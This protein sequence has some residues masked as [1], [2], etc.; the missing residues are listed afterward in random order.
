MLA[1]GRTCREHVSFGA[2]GCKGLVRLASV[3]TLG[4]IGP[5]SPIFDVTAFRP[6]TAVRFG[7]AGHDAL[8]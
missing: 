2:F 4:G 5:G 3:A 1:Y 6:V 7:T 8:Y